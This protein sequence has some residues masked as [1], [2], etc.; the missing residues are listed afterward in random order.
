MTTYKHGYATLAI[1]STLYVAAVYRY[2]T[3]P[4]YVLLATIGFALSYLVWGLAHH[5]K[6]IN[7]HARIMLEYLLVALLGVAIVATLLI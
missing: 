1:L 5:L 6:A 7:L 4:K 2:Q 3:V